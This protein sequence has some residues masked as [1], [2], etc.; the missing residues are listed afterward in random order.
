MY[1]TDICIDS[2][3]FAVLAASR[4]QHDAERWNRKGADGPVHV[5]AGQCVHGAADK[6]GRPEPNRH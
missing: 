5:G 3:T 1:I 6:R 4:R 2:I